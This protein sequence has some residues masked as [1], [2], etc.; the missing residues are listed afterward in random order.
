M[1]VCTCF[2]SSLSVFFFFFFLRAVSA[3]YGNSQA[4]GQMGAIAAGLHHSN[5]RSD[6][7]FDLH[8]SSQQCQILNLLSEARVGT[9]VLMDTSQGLLLLSHDGS[10][11]SWILNLLSH[12]I[13]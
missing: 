6:H 9:C 8:H 2:L 11:T 7:I 5:A 13:L 10:S 12:N 3:A 1:C 4:R